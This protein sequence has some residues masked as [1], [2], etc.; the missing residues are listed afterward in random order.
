M[1]LLTLRSPSVKVPVFGIYPVIYATLAIQGALW[2]VCQL[3]FVRALHKVPS[4]T[5]VSGGSLVT[6]TALSTR[7]PAL[8]VA[9]ITAVLK[10]PRYGPKWR[11]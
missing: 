10:E 11:V 4:E 6:Q 5:E 7:Q 1:F 2:P 8:S 3:V 9:Y